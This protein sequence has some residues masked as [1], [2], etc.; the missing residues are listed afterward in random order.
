MLHPL[1]AKAQQ[2]LADR[3]D[4]IVETETGNY[5]ATFMA[6]DR[7]TG[8]V[9]KIRLFAVDERL[10]GDAKSLS[11]QVGRLV[12]LTSDYVLKIHN[13]QDIRVNDMAGILVIQEAFNGVALRDMLPSFHRILQL[14]G[15]ANREFCF[16]AVQMAEAVRAIHGAG[17]VHYAVNPLGFY[18]DPATRRF[19][20]DGLAWEH[21]WSPESAA[22]VPDAFEAALPYLS[23]EQIGRLDLAVD[24][25]AN[26]YSLGVLFYEMLTGKH[27]FSATA[28]SGVLYGHTARSPLP[29]ADANPALDNVLSRLVLKL[30]AKHPDDRYQS[31]AGL[32]F[33]LA[34]LSSRFEEDRRVTDFIPGRKD[35]SAEFAIP[36]RIYGRDKEM[37]LLRGHFDRARTGDLSVVMITGDT[38]VGKTEVVRRLGA[39]VREMGGVFLTGKFEQQQQSVPLPLGAPTTALE[40]VANW[41][42][43][44]SPESIERWREKILAAVS[45]NGQVLVDMIPEMA[46]IIGEQPPLCDLPPMEASLRVAMVMEKFGS[47]ILEKDHPVAFFFDDMQWADDVSLTHGLAFLL[48]RERRYCLVLGTY[49]DNEVDATHPLMQYVEKL[50][51]VG[52]G[53]ETLRMSPLDLNRTTTMVAEILCRPETSVASLA[54]IVFEKT[55]GNPFFIRQFMNSLHASGLIYYDMHQ[56]EWAWNTDRIAAAD[57][58]DNVARLL[59]ATIDKLSAATLTVL[60]TAACA[61]NRIDPGL[62]ARILCRDRA[63]IVAHMRIAMETGLLRSFVDTPTARQ[64]PEKETAHVWEFAHDHILQAVYHTIPAN[65]ARGLHWSVGKALLA[66]DS[67][68]ATDK[69]IFDIAHQLRRGMPPDLTPDGKIE[70]ARLNLAAGRAAM[71]SVGFETA[72]RYFRH[73][74]ELLP[75]NSWNSHYELSSAIHAGL[76][77]CE[78]VIGDFDAS[79]RLFGLLL[80]RA[81]ALPDRAR[82]Y[83]AMIELHTAVGN[84]DKALTLGRRALEMLGIRMPLRTNRLELVL[85]LLKLRFMWGFRRLSSVMEI[86]ENKDELLSITETLLVNIG[87]PTYYVDPQLCQWLNTTGILL[88][89]RNPKEGVPVQHAPLGLIILGA[90]LGSMFGFISM[91]R[92]YAKIGMRMLERQSPGTHR[93]I[94]YFVSAYFNRHWYQP[95]RKNIDS[96]K[97]AYRQALKSGDISYACHSINGM[98]MVHLF[99]GDNLDMINAHHKR[100]ETFIRNSRSPFNVSTYLAIQQFYRGLKGYTF[101]PVSL[102]EPGYDMTAEFAVA[103]EGG[104]LLLQ[105][106]LL[107]FQLKLFVIYRQWDNAV[108]VAERIRAKNYQPVGTLI[109]TEYYFFSFLSAIALVAA[110]TPLEQSLRCRQQAALA[111]KKMKQW[112]RLRPDNFEP[113]LRLMEAEQARTDSRPSKV[114]Q[115]YRQ[116]VASATAGGFTQLAALACESAG[117]YLSAHGDKIAARAYLIEARKA[118]EV[119]GATAKVRDM[120]KQYAAIF[121]VVSERAPSVLERMDYNAVVEALQAV[122]QEIM[123]GKLL[124]RLMEITMEATGANRAVFISNKDNRLFV[125]VERRGDEAGQTLLKAEPLLPEKRKLMVSVVYYVKQ[126]QQL[127]VINDV[128]KAP[129]PFHKIEDTADPPRA[130]VCMPMCRNRRLV[131]ILYLENTLTSNV[132]RDDRIELLKLIA[133]QAAISFE[134]ASLYEHVMKNEQDLKQLSEKLR[135]LYSELMLTEERERRRIATELHDRIGHALA[136]TKI[137]LEALA[138]SVAADHRQRLTEIIGM[139]DQSITDT[140]TLTFEISPPIL[141]H[142][143]LSAALDW[144]CEETQKKHGIRVSFTDSHSEAVIDQKMAV[145]CFQILRELMFN[146]VKHARADQIHLV[147]RLENDRLHLTIQDNGIGFDH[148]R[149]VSGEALPDGGF[150]LFSINERLRLVEGRMDIDSGKNRGTLIDVIVPLKTTGTGSSGVDGFRSLS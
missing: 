105:F 134:N 18:F 100:Y 27:P 66:E 49:R 132:F 150:G 63:D 98:S 82:A 118:Y 137:G 21:A 8:Q 58:T 87:L 124:T 1:S 71:E 68:V 108:A 72:A 31:A 90:F 140:R 34:D 94:A 144:L 20:L 120:E 86:P 37:T 141:Y 46:L 92:L 29:P 127:V 73:A 136:G 23:P 115:R 129:A 26:L 43:S 147:L 40:S 113:M 36:D 114:L 11:E 10:P 61:G 80:H 145:L 45:P 79:E 56:G 122:S 33:D 52:I 57:I 5:T 4:R 62:L 54:G 48:A 14:E 77:K 59:S 123:V 93:A 50:Q 109:L 78:F 128:N 30:L 89:I 117:N 101:S 107:L 35:A 85:M 102:N 99:L 3:Y 64:A 111:L 51:Q 13:Y 7:L 131:G 19:K 138:Q 135:N 12:G 96:F 70:L 76:A 126:T 95:A 74:R 142:L 44:Q 97:R 28:P 91:G 119:W 143:G 17:L 106:F 67:S 24:F 41:L 112:R 38:G 16:V 83:N 149:Q 53:V 139:I 148:A 125:E 2:I 6:V 65:T 84:I 39:Y 110:G 9:V 103:V 81:P 60:Q 130:L 69:K 32:L 25:R 75:D 133:S 116:A 47:L 88:G 146:A 55:A 15:H 121:A 22:F 104:N 42:L